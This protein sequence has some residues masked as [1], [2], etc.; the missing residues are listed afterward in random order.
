MTIH[1]AKGLEFPLACVADLG[2]SQVREAGSGLEVS[3]DGRTGL[4]LASL[5][6]ETR[7]T[8]DMERLI[9]EQRAR[10]DEEEKRIFH[11]AMTRA[12]EHL[13]VSGAV[14]PERWPEP[15][16]LGPPIDWIWRALAPGAKDALSEASLGVTSGVRCELVGPDGVAGGSL[17]FGGSASPPSDGR[18]AEPSSAPLARGLP[19]RFA[20]VPAPRSLPVA[21]LSYSA[22]E[23]YKRCGYRFYLERVARLRGPDPASAVRLAPPARNGQ[24]VL[25]LEEPPAAEP[26]AGVTPLLRGTIVHELLERFDLDGGEP[27][28]PAEVEELLEAHGAPVSG[29]EVERVRGLIDAFARS[30]LR[31]RAAAGRRV[32]RELPFAFELRIGRADARSILVNGV[33]DVHVEEAD[34]VL[35]VDYKTDPLDGADPGPIVAERYTTQR[36]VYALAALR[37]GAPRVDVAY[38]FLEAPG[39]PVEATFVAAQADELEAQLLDLARG[40]VDGRFEPT[41]EPHRELCLTCPGRAALCSW[42]PDRTLREHPSRAIPS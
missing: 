16:P 23:S 21:Q 27:P 40:V 18:P 38:A 32:R 11:V 28:A 29:E 12:R 41:A 9:E 30:A 13:V 8:L 39:A 22:L 17:R 35:V 26:V 36:L 15:K 5:S 1:A 10:A 37:S 19:P 7:A 33:V 34:G 3:E 6:G 25:R 4:R 24:L 2:R 14:D 31:A 42:G 20:S